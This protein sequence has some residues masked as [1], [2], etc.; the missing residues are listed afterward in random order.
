M[1]ATP[2]RGVWN[3]V[4]S[5][6]RR[7]C[8]V[9][10]SPTLT[11]R[12]ARIAGL[13]SPPTSP[14]PQAAMMA[15]T[16]IRICALYLSLPATAT[17]PLRFVFP[18][19][20]IH[21]GVTSTSSQPAL[22]SVAADIVV[23]AETTQSSIASATTE[24]DLFVEKYKLSAECKA[25][26]IKNEVTSVELICDLTEGDLKEIGLLKGSQM[27]IRKAQD[28]LQKTTYPNAAPLV[29]AASDMPVNALTA[30][31]GSSVPT[32]PNAVETVYRAPKYSPG[33][34]CA[35][36]FDVHH[37]FISYRVAT[38][39]DVA[40]QLHN[41]LTNKK[42]NEEFIHT[43]LDKCCLEYGKEWEAGFLN[44]LKNSKVIVLLL[45]EKGLLKTQDAHSIPDNQFLEIELALSHW[46]K[47]QNSACPLEL[48]VILMWSETGGSYKKWFFD[49]STF[50]DEMHCHP[51]SPR[52]RTIKKTFERLA[53]IQIKQAVDADAVRDQIPLIRGKVDKVLTAEASK[54]YRSNGH[55]Y[56]TAHEN[57]LL[58]EFLEP[59]DSADD[60]RA[61]EKSYVPGTRH[62]LFDEIQAWCM[63]SDADRSILWVN[64]VAGVGK[65]VAAAQIANILES[66]AQLVA[67]IFL[68]YNDV[69]KNN[70]LNVLKTIAYYLCMWYAPIG[71]KLL[72]ANHSQESLDK[73]S[74]S[75]KFNALITQPL[76]ALGSYKPDKAVVILIDGLDECSPRDSLLGLLVSMMLGLKL[77]AP[78]LKLLLTSRPEKDIA[79]AFVKL[80]QEKIEPSSHANL[81][82]LKV[83]IEHSLKQYHNMTFEDTIRGTLMLL[84]PPDTETG[85]VT[86]DAS[87]TFVWIRLILNTIKKEFDDGRLVN[88]ELI[89]CINNQASNVDALYK[90][91]FDKAMIQHTDIE[92]QLLLV[93]SSICTAQTLL[94]P[95]MLADLFFS[96]VSQPSAFDDIHKCLLALSVVLDP[97]S[98]G[99]TSSLALSPHSH[100][101]FN[102]KSVA[103]YLLGEISISHK[104]H[105]PASFHIDFAEF[106]LQNILAQEPKMN[107]CNIHNVHKNIPEL[108]LKVQK[109]LSTALQYSILNWIP[110][111]LLGMNPSSMQQ[112]TVVSSI[113][114]FF[115]S[116]VLFWME[117]GS[118]L[119]KTKENLGQLMSLMQSTTITL[120][121]NSHALVK[122]SYRFLREFGD[123][124]IASAPQVYNSGLTFCPTAI[125]LRKR[126]SHLKIPF[127]AAPLETAWNACELTITGHTSSV[128][129][130]AVSP[131]GKWIVSGSKDGSVKVWDALT[132]QLQHTLIGHSEPVF[133]VALSPDGKWIVSGSMDQSIKVWDALNGQ[134][135]HTLEGHYYSVSSVCVSPDGKWIV[136]MDVGG[137]KMIQLLMTLD[138]CEEGSLN[139]M[140]NA[141]SQ[142]IAWESLGHG[143][144]KKGTMLTKI[145]DNLVDSFQENCSGAL[146]SFK[147]HPVILSI[148]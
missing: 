78:W 138:K 56:L 27:K 141:A 105:V 34:K 12:A 67:A 80:P 114:M 146:I 32:P 20:H 121:R 91:T 70:P 45:S 73:L 145:P 61:L 122:D 102:H 128:E 68:K 117:C 107:I 75:E 1:S 113:D 115:D 47:S 112:T 71:A 39:K 93:I 35:G 53:E 40:L 131:E 136:S 14:T 66:H 86:A 123:P 24:F 25:L 142:D 83:F 38:E 55:L 79:A 44:G 65:S 127:H 96:S 119:R 135:E 13:L 111:F 144:V 48:M 21:G 2:I 130:V 50:L 3:P 134:L 133:S 132:A 85:I 57:R 19:L 22:L 100:I 37:V 98:N 7:G 82:D 64:A 120:K 143:W 51:A 108:D 109:K 94:T 60:R 72:E 4:A 106:C 88:L 89:E 17:T 43:Y 63:N 46:E 15:A 76:Q 18:F 126:Y 147:Q 118:L 6:S 84:K 23:A 29:G 92:S 99:L 49:T 90:K 110:H 10:G 9:L 30:T 59:I 77:Q 97:V 5:E 81:T 28:F 31:F 33:W 54:E 129:S 140:Q 103:D 8:C 124:I 16:F 104:F 42:R 69:K 87:K 148:E 36:L 125:P 95:I 116:H 139:I 26:L 58:F 41:G 52:E 11:S 101:R 74:L 62:W 137:Y